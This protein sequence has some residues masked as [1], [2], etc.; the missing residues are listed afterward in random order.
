MIQSCL[1]PALVVMTVTACT[2]SAN[3]D[4][5]MAN[6]LVDLVV[7]KE[8]PFHQCVEIGPHTNVTEYS[9]GFDAPGL[10]HPKAFEDARL[11]H[12]ASELAISDEEAIANDVEARV[13][14]IGEP[15]TIDGTGSCSL[16]IRAP[17]FSQHFAFIEFSTPSGVIGAYA[18]ERSDGSWRAAERIHLGNW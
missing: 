8:A 2:P 13:L 1:L 6:E 4:D 5:V 16:R 14:V 3:T 17:V 10:L 11:S 15:D 9:E 12:A 7:A 18:F